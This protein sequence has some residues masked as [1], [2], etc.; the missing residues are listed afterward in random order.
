[1]SLEQSP[2]T[3]LDAILS[4]PRSAELA[5]LALRLGLGAVFL[6]HALAKVFVFTLPGTVAFFASSG[7]PGWTAYPVFLAELLGGV[8]L[9]TGFRTRLVALGLLPVMA[10]ALLVHLPSGWMFT[11]PGGGWEYVAFLMVALVA[12][13]L[14]GDGA[15]AAGQRRRW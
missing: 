6:A 8:A 15:L 1:M 2:R 9:V 3:R 13:A 4:V 14:L 11:N 7:F 10:G 5:A 12:Q